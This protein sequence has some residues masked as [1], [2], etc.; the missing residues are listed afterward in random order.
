MVGRPKI[1]L[2]FG[3]GASR[4]WA[5]IGVIDALQ[6]AGFPIDV[7]A[8]TSAGAVIGAYH[9]AGALDRLRDWA[10]KYTSSL[11]T[12]SFL[13]VSLGKGGLI[14]GRRFID[15]VA[16]H[17][18][19]R[20]FEE[21]SIPFGA[22]ATDLTRMQE[23]HLTEG[24]LLPVLRASVSIPGFLSP[25]RHKDILLVDGG[26]LN[27]VPVNL[28]R[29]LGA[30]VVIAVDL[31]SAPPVPEIEGVTQVV[32]RTVETMMNR[33]RLMNREFAPADFYIEPK[34]TDFAL[35]DFHRSEE[36]IKTGYEETKR[37]LPDLEKA[38]SSM[39][40][41]SRRRFFVQVPEFARR[42]ARIRLSR[43]VPASST[44]SSPDRSA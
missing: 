23:V 29:A 17:L 18:P 26:L 6:E 11:T 9:A 13:D 14:N 32:N 34:V 31:N 7:V 8:G 19:V 22:V 39:F 43:E 33:I 24:A 15:T 38:L 5:H 3:S 36:A 35:L 40:S 37:R 27:P 42:L 4:G 1:G 20:T 2:A 44:P 28:A 41:Y 21:L 30:D 25:L 16:E 12:I 10:D